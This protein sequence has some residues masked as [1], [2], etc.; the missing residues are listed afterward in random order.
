MAESHGLEWVTGTF[1]LEP[2][3]TAEPD[4]AKVELLARKHLKIEEKASCKVIFYAQ[5]AFNK[6]YKIETEAGSSLMRVTLPVDPSNKTNS[7]VAT[8]RFVQQNTD[9]PVPQILAFD[10][11]RKNELGFE[12]ILM[13]MLPGTTLRARWRKLPETAKRDLVKQVAT[14]QAQLFRYKFSV[15]G[16]MFI[17]QEA[18]LTSTRSPYI[19]ITIDTE[20]AQKRIQH[21]LP[22]LGQL[23]SLIFFWGDHITQN[24]P[25]GPFSNVEDW[26]HARL[27]FVLTDQEKI[28]NNSEDEDEI[29]DAEDAMKLAKRLL[30]LLPGVFSCHYSAQST[31]LH[32]DDLS[33]QNILVDSGGRITGVIDWECVSALP[34]WKACGLPEFLRGRERNEKPSKD[35]YISDDSDANTNNNTL[36]PTNEVLD[37]EG[38][39]S[40]YWEHLLDY[41]LTI[42]RELFLKEMGNLA[43]TWIEEMENGALLANFDLAVQNCDN[44]WCTKKV[45]RWLDGMEKGENWSLMK[46]LR[47]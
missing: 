17:K 16:N 26:I 31:V 23:V 14:Y 39:N 7:E 5:G 40:L 6:L 18:Q 12:W 1:G 2:H 47:E 35:Q 43:P 32:H 19:P 29:E 24:V 37:N 38:V 9:I 13:E 42:L 46:S 25:R 41:E 30:E 33:M 27:A 28:L 10:D 8:I 11:S 36:G 20:Q 21:T 3:W 4:I 22:A 34:L 45:N 15:I 44:G